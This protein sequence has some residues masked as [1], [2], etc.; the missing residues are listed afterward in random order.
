MPRLQLLG[1]FLPRSLAGLA[2]LLVSTVPAIAAAGPSAAQLQ[3]LETALNGTGELRGAME[4]GP[5]LD[6][7]LVELRRRSVLRQFPDARWQLT[8]GK[9]LRDGRS[10][11]QLQVTGSRQEGPTRYR[12]DAQQQL[13]LSSSG[14]P[15]GR[16]NGQI[17]IREQTLMR[18]GEADL[19]VSLLIPDAVLTGQRYDVDALFDEPLE[20]AIAAG[21]LVALTGQQVN[22]LESPE[23]QLGALGGGGLF[24]SVQAPFTP[25]SQT[26]AIL[27]VHPKGIVSATKR[28]LVVADKTQLD[29]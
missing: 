4:D 23:L 13:V 1:R 11:V 18:S 15:G 24:K 28:V 5:G 7:T 17:V 25:G 6:V 12:L 10:T 22:A 16:I 2:V 8:T 20:G 26:W 29:P 21:G 27:L 14:G 19:P 3:A 9:P